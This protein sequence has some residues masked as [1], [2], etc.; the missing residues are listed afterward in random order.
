MALK[1]QCPNCGMRLGYEGLCWV[2]RE[3]QERGEAC[4]WTEAEI[5]E[6]LEHLIAYAERLNSWKTEEY[7]T[8][9]DKRVFMEVNNDRRYI[10]WIIQSVH[11]FWQFGMFCYYY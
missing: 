10:I 8:A 1:Y 3:E 9:C 11:L 5:K 7:K 2:C 4:G 6:K